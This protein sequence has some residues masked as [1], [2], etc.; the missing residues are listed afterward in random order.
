MG[1]VI[2][3]FSIEDWL[4][5][6]MLKQSIN[7]MTKIDSHKYSLEIKGEKEIF[8]HILDTYHVA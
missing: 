4:T 3:P 8:D 1:K 2:G 7:Y 5:L 6:S